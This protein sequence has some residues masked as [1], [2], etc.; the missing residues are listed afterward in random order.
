MAAVGVLAAA[1]QGQGAFLGLLMPVVKKLRLS[2]HLLVVALGKDVPGDAVLPEVLEEG[3]AGGQLSSQASTAPLAIPRGQRR[4]TSS[5]KPS[6]G[7]L[8]S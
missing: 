8:G 3:E 7:S 6:E 5:R 4:I 2:G 1:E